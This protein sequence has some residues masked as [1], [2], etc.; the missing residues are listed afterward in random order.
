LIDEAALGQAIESGHLRG[1]AL[2][3]FRNG[4]PADDH[5]LLR[6]PQV[7]VTPHTGAHTDE[8]VNAM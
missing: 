2:G 7:M 5:P 3:C 8:A 1:A 4:P 6:L